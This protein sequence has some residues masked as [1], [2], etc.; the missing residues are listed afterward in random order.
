LT[1][2]IST[3]LDVEILMRNAVRIYRGIEVSFG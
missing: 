1:L 2:V 3:S